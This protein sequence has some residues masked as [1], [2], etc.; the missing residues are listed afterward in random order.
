[1]MAFAPFG[2]LAANVTWIERLR[3]QDQAL[4]QWTFPPCARKAAKSGYFG[5]YRNIAPPV[6][7]KFIVRMSM[8]TDNDEQ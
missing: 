3:N 6:Q 7:A 8:D 5:I 4:A 2:I 1:M